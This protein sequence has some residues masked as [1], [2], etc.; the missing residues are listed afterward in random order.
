M[1]DKMP[2]NKPELVYHWVDPD[3]MNKPKSGLFYI[4]IDAWWL[5]NDKGEIA[6][7]Q[8]RT[9]G[10]KI[11]YTMPQCNL[12]RR[13]SELIARGEPIKQIPAVYIPMSVGDFY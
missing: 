2:G 5:V 8:G 10:R 1:T 12:D 3:T 7:Y 9:P 6:F 13:V 11:I 4:H